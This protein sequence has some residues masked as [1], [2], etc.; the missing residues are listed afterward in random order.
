MEFYTLQ[1]YSFRVKEKC[2]HS[3]KNLKEFVASRLFLQEML[4][5]IL[6]QYKK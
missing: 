2:R 6:W 5:E 3:Q 1:D 4:K